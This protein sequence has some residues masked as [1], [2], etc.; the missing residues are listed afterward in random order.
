M[1]NLTTARN[2]CQIG[3][4]AVSTIN[5]A[6]LKTPVGSQKSKGSIQIIKATKRLIDN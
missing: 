4:F 2:G 1:L 3:I 6:T 5:F